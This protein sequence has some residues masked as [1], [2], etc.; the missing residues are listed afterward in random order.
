MFVPGRSGEWLARLY[1]MKPNAIYQGLYCGDDKVFFCG[2]PLTKRDKKIVY[3][4]Q[5]IERKNVRRMCEAF[6]CIAACWPEWSLELYGAGPLRDELL[7]FAKRCPAIHVHGFAQVAELA[8]VYRRSRIFIL[9]S[10]EE[11]WG[12]VVH[13]AALSG[14]FLLLSDQIG[15]ADDFADRTNARR[16]DPLSADSISRAMSDA[17]SLSE[18]DLIQAMSTSSKL[19]ASFGPCRFAESVRAIV[20]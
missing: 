3:V 18:P 15:A 9:P 4:G 11:H 10:L 1:G 2:E 13:E 17:L 16:F 6:A 5:F 7:A 12:V 14:C 20:K 19:A 8:E